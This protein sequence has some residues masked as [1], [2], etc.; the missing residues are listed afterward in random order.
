MIRMPILYVR[1]VP[2][3]VYRSLQAR[4][5]A[6]GR[7]LNAEALEILEEAA[8]RSSDTPITDRLFALSRGIK[9]PPGFPRAEDLIRE[10]RE[11]RERRY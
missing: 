2:S 5:K 1:N 7:S 10:G 9:L 11:E 4:A 3:Q 8:T 6:Q